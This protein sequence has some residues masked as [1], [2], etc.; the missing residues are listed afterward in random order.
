MSAINTGLGRDGVL[1]MV[2][3]LV[4]MTPERM[5]TMSEGLPRILTSF[6]T[7][8]CPKKPAKTDTAMR[9][10]AAK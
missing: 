4:N 10:K 7:K 3:A 5:N 6:L 8:D 2:S 1:P 9:Y